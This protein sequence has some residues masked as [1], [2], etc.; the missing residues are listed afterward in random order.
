M[1]FVPALEM[2]LIDA[3]FLLIFGG[4]RNDIGAVTAPVYSGTAC[5]VQ[6]GKRG[7]VPEGRIFKITTSKHRQ[8]AGARLWGEVTRQ[9]VA[10]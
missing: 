9:H 6:A 7:A 10:R 3:K 1:N 4:V 5:S 8:S 2:R